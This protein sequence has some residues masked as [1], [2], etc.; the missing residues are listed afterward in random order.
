MRDFNFNRLA[1]VMVGAA[2]GCGFGAV[3]TGSLGAAAFGALAGFVVT[4]TIF[5][6]T[7]II[8]PPE[9]KGKRR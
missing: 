1:L 8:D 2:A 5:V 4:E 6:L 7:G 3:A 9:E